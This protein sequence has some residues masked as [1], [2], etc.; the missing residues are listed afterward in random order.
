MKNV[1]MEPMKSYEL[2]RYLGG[3]EDLMKMF[4]KGREIPI[5]A[6]NG[7]CVTIELDQY[8]FYGKDNCAIGRLDTLLDACEAL[9]IY[10]DNLDELGEEDKLRARAMFDGLAEL[11]RA[12]RGY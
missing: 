8:V 2:P 9:I 5:L 11:V 4:N 3:L 10:G 12:I 7:Y 1:T 6:Y